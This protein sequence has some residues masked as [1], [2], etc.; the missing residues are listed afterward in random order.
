MKQLPPAK[1]NQLIIA[2]LI[3]AALIGF[4][5]FFLIVP[6]NASNAAIANEVK[7]IRNKLDQ[8]K[9]TIKQATLADENLKKVLNQLSE[10][11]QDVASGDVSAWTYD[12][13]RGFK[14]AYHNVDVQN[15]GSP[16]PGEME[17]ISNFPYKQVKVALN[18]TAFYH[19]L[20]KFVMDFENKFPHMRVLNFSAEPT[21]TG[22]RLNFHMDVATLVK[23]NS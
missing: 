23:P 9:D 18:G 11:E 15:M 17:L 13:L 10:S 5:Y 12:M 19:D 21:G 14:F 20:G 7:T 4:V 2:L 1:R 8:Y 6:Q 16:A 3:A 22:E